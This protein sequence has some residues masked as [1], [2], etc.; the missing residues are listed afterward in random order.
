VV[1]KEADI[2][3]LGIILLELVTGT[4]AFSELKTPSDLIR[5]L[6]AYQ[7]PASL[8]GV[9]PPELAELIRS[10]LAQPDKRPTVDD[11]LAYE[12]LNAQN[13]PDPQHL[14][15]RT[16]TSS[17]KSIQILVGKEPSSPPS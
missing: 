10:C 5:A 13:P 8:A 17:D 4:P 2:W 3:A 1:S 14:H 9:E 12:L 11:L 15:V 6:T 7:L 16:N